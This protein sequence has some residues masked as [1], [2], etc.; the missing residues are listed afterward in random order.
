MIKIFFEYIYIYV[1]E[2]QEVKQKYLRLFFD[3]R[4]VIMVGNLSRFLGG[5]VSQKKDNGVL[6]GSQGSNDVT[7]PSEGAVPGIDERSVATPPS[8]IVTSS[9]LPWPDK[10]F[11]MLLT[12][13]STLPGQDTCRDVYRNWIWIA[14]CSPFP[15]IFFFCS[16][17]SSLA[18][19]FRFF[20][21]LFFEKKVN[22]F[23]G[24]SV[25]ET[26]LIKS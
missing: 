21:F 16:S 11:P 6:W 14:P 26:C 17:Y 2:N 19:S 13:T 1:F 10:I 4:K 5:I 24:K 25:Y 12:S 9:W 22:L 7:G 18:N 20:F 15:P 3:V 8:T 23:I